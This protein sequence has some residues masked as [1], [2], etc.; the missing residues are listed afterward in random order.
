[1]LNSISVG[2]Y[3]NG[4]K[5]DWGVEVDEHI[6]D[7]RQGRKH[8]TVSVVNLNL[9]ST[10]KPV[11][12]KSYKIIWL[13]MEILLSK[14]IQPNFNGSNTFETIKRCSTQGLFE[15]MSVNYS[16]RTGGIKGISF[17]FL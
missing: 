17:E 5:F 6:K 9:V 12:L 13:L 11:I 2:F 14:Y 8:V 3:K 7:K 15:L 4:L 10:L 16:A 1:M